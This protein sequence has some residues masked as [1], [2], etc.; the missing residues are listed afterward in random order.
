MHPTSLLLSLHLPRAPFCL[1][2][3]V[4]GCACVHAGECVF[5]YFLVVLT[6]RSLVLCPREEQMPLFSTPGK[7]IYAHAVAA[8]KSQHF[9]L[10]FCPLTRVITCVYVCV[11]VSLSRV[12]K[13]GRKAP[14]LL[15]IAPVNRGAV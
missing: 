8:V 7:H 14:C 6:A 11:C 10:G 4:C 15:F 3:C 9:L 12:F 1:S 2:M 13:R 5:M